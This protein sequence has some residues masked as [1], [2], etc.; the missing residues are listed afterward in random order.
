MILCHDLVSF[1]KEGETSPQAHF[2]LCRTPRAEPGN[3]L[4]YANDGIAPTPHGRYCSV[5]V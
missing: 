5:G 4:D 3:G 2:D 1:T